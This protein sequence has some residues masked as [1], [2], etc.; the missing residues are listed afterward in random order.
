MK[1]SI[2]IPSRK[3]NN[4]TP[5]LDSLKEHTNDYEVIV[6]TEGGFAE[7]INNGVKKAKG[8]Y[9]V[10]IHDDN[11]VCPGWLD[12]LSE[13]GCFNVLESAGWIWG[14]FYPGGFCTDYN[15]TPDYSMFLL[16]SNKAVKEIF[17]LDEAFS[18]P[19]CQDVDMGFHIRSKG[20][21]IKP[22]SGKI[23]H[24]WA[25]GNHIGTNET[26]LKQKWGI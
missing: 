17:P 19:W 14:G 23:I 3:G 9:I 22:L 25:G 13:V 7:A 4:L 1:F 5:I 6:E 10:L 8:E 18:N 20:Y 12:E 15:Q 24:N 16:I 2:I 26:Y 21:K 11:I